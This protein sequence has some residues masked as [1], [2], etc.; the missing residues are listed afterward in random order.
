[1]RAVT[2]KALT[3]RTGVAVR[4]WRWLRS[5]AATFLAV[6]VLVAVFAAAVVVPFVTTESPSAV[7]LDR[8]LQRPVWLGGSF[9]HPLGTDQL[10]RD[11]LLQLALALRVSAVVAVVSVLLAGAVGALLGVFAGFRGGV[12]DFFVSRLVEAQLAL[13]LIVLAIAII[14]ALGPSIPT[15]VLAIALNG[16]VPFALLAR[17]ETLVVREKPFV[18]LARVAG[19][20]PAVIVVR[21]L[22]PNVLPSLMILASQQFAVAV[23]EESGLSFLGL[24]V[25]PPRSSLGA[26]VG[27][28]REVLQSAPW[29]PLTPVVALAVVALCL[30]V[31]GDRLR[32]G[33][34]TS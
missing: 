34:R 19:V 20:R 33:F 1:M 28:S 30:N 11:V 10:G 27:Q 24:G 21:H 4:V 29:L 2:V 23:I 16:W 25:Q 26:M 14:V 15:L 8:A 3:P 13:P 9:A 22:L 18:E 12:V 7:Q 6:L 32:R 17:T 5:D 31:I